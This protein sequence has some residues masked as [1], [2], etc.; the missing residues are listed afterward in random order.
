MKI[1]YSFVEEKSFAPVKKKQTFFNTTSVYEEVSSKMV[2][3]SGSFVC[4]LFSTSFFFFFWP[5][6]QKKEDCE[7]SKRFGDGFLVKS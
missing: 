4:L 3:F 2:K 7:R 6:P 5:S 1:L